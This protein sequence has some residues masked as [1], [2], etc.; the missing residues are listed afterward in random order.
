MTTN[1][2]QSKRPY[3]STSRLFPQ[4]IRLISKE[5]RGGGFVR[6][7]AGRKRPARAPKQ[8][9]GGDKMRRRGEAF[10]FLVVVSVAVVAS[11]FWLLSAC[12][13]HATA[14]DFHPNESCRPSFKSPREF[15]P[16]SV[17]LLSLIL[18]LALASMCHD[19][20]DR[21]M[22]APV[23]RFLRRP[24]PYSTFMQTCQQHYRNTL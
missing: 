19:A 12:F 20:L 15:H 23:H 4:Y 17:H 22:N 1:L 6:W 2:N 11:D 16:P 21:I 18:R 8:Y 10:L 9:W 5:R 3:V 13:V 24:H 7:W 14:P